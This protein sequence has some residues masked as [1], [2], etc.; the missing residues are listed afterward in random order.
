MIGLGES[1]PGVVAELGES[2]HVVDLWLLSQ[3]PLSC[4]AC[5]HASCSP[6][7]KGRSK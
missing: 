5:V 7:S 4:F 3:S 1:D 2:A 6:F